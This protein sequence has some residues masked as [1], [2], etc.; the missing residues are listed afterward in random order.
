MSI[1]KIYNLTD[2]ENYIYNLTLSGD[3]NVI[4]I[5][6]IEAKN[7]EIKSLD[8]IV[9]KKALY[10]MFKRHPFFRTVVKNNAYLNKYFFEIHSETSKSEEMMNF[11]LSEIDGNYSEDKVVEEFEILLSKP[12]DYEN[13]CLL[14][15]F[16]LINFIEKKKNFSIF[17]LIV[18]LYMTDGLNITALI[19]EFTNIINSLLNKT[20][21]E[22]MLNKLE[23]CPNM[24]ELMIE[25]GF[26]ND[27]V[28]N[29][30]EK[31]ITNERL[32]HFN[33]PLLFKNNEK[34][35]RTKMNLFKI[36]SIISEKIKLQSKE[37]KIRLTG[38]F[39]TIALNTF[40]ELYDEYNI[41]FPRDFSCMLP[42]NLR[43]RLGNPEVDLSD[44]RFYAVLVS[45]NL[46]YPNIKLGSNVDQIWENAAY[47][48]KIIAEKTHFEN[49][50]LLQYS[51][52]SKYID[53]A[54]K[55]FNEH[56]KSPAAELNRYNFCDFLVSNL[57]THVSDRKI[58]VEGDYKLKEVYHGDSICSN[59]SYFSTFMLHIISF[60]SQMMF[61]LSTNRTIF[62]S[63]HA[64][65]F[66]DIFKNILE[67]IFF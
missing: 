20:E 65:R 41:V 5:G 55:I 9:V 52:N 18:P 7:E 21:C 39:I 63:E 50:S 51:H 8:S 57:G 48:N 24:H 59:P 61:Q 34:N 11:E 33:M 26:F 23:L 56:Q 49:G 2:Y 19:F 6:K 37:R 62:S 29:E 30:V 17:G 31:L 12:F 13:N 22:E 25:R 1:E 3:E 16:K 28:K 15:R 35:N 67:K 64:D 38:F 43:F 58:L 32:I 42:A 46:F 54:N 14:W 10:F 45:I 47:V 53:E 66:V 4:G 44:M 27:D 40:K 36:D 60:N